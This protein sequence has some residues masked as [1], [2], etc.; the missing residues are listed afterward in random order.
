MRADKLIINDFF[1][2]YSHF[3]SIVSFLSALNL[4][5]WKLLYIFAYLN[6]V[7]DLSVFY[8]VDCSL[9]SSHCASRARWFSG[10]AFDTSITWI[11]KENWTTSSNIPIYF[12]LQNLLPWNCFILIFHKLTNFFNK[13]PFWPHEYHRW[14]RLNASNE[15]FTIKQ[16]EFFMYMHVIASIKL[17]F[18]IIRVRI[19]NGIFVALTHSFVEKINCIKSISKFIDGLKFY[20]YGMESELLIE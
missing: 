14:L 9:S 10:S 5:T 13:I 4:N 17:F 16:Y 8:M 3:L 11:E 7:Y 12:I 18:V 19:W 2:Q 15:F 20:D 6:R 1:A